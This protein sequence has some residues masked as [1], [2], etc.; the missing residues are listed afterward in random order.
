MCSKARQRLRSASTTAS[1]EIWSTST[2]NHGAAFR[3]T[4][5]TA[6]A[7]E[8]SGLGNADGTSARSNGF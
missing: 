4:H 5:F 1:R 2:L 6:Y 7:T 3:E 8:K